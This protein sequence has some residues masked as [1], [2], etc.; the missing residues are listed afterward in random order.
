[1]QLFLKT[2]PVQE[3]L[4]LEEVKTYLRIGSDQEDN[5]LKMLIRAARAHV[6]SLTGRALL[7]QQW[8]LHIKP[9]YPRGSPLVKKEGKRLEIELS[10][11]P[12]LEV[13]EV[14]IEGKTIP[15]EVEESRILLSSLFWDK[16]ISVIY[17]AGYGETADSIPPDL[18]MAVLMATRFFYDNQK[19][20]LPLLQP[21]KVFHLG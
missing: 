14:K 19:G 1:M 21:Y 15:Y 13:E 3:P 2:P 5:F 11:P 6:E 17:W 16:E 8:A 7:K 9:P 12:L 18:K 20:D 4:T 10:Q